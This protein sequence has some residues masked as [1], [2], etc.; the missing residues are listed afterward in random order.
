M[1]D[2]MVCFL[3]MLARHPRGIKRNAMLSSLSSP[4]RYLQP[5]T[6]AGIVLVLFLVAGLCPSA[7]GHESGPNDTRDSQLNFDVA[8]IHQDNDST[9]ARSK[10]EFRN[11]Q[12]EAES[13]QLQSLLEYAYGI[14]HNQISWKH[15]KL[16]SQRFTIRARVGSELMAALSGK[17]EAETI[18]AHRQLVKNLLI[19]RFNLL[20]H[21]ET[22]DLPAFVLTTSKQG[23]KFVQS[24]PEVQSDPSLIKSPQ[25]SMH[26][27]GDIH[28]ENLQ[29]SFFVDFLSEEVGHPVIDNT[30]IKGAATF[31]LKWSSE[32]NGLFGSIM[33]G[34]P[35]MKS[36]G[37]AHSRGDEGETEKTD[38]PRLSTALQEQLGLILKYQR[39]PQ[40][41]LIIDRVDLPSEN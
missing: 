21:E 15:S 2:R 36:N 5:F 19:T 26:G 38:A 22:V 12:F 32:S 39:M 14:S 17:S 13:E 8:S 4:S 34:A 35:E 25:L 29:F 24:T 3:K 10:L 6:R 18:A 27:P 1:S 20:T 33:Q 11:D 28:A 9:F 31:D 41:Q 7:Q 37:S 30:G 16:T 23:V 40:Q